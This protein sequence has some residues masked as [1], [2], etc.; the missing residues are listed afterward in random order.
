M[1]VLA[2]CQPALSVGTV[3]I[4]EVSFKPPK[5]DLKAFEHRD[6]SFCVAF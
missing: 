3:V 5:G 6:D 4:L 1:D 2:P